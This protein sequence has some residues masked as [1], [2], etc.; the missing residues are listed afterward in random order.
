MGGWSSQLLTAIRQS[1]L[2]IFSPGIFVLI[3]LSPAFSIFFLNGSNTFLWTNTWNTKQLTQFFY[4]ELGLAAASLFIFFAIYR[5]Y[6]S[7]NERNVFHFITWVNR[8]GVFLISLPLLAVLDVKGMEKNSPFLA[9]T[10]VLLASLCLMIAIYHESKRSRFHIT[11]GTER[12]FIAGLSGL[13]PVVLLVIFYGSLL[14]WFSVQNLK[15]F[16]VPSFDLAIYD[17]LLY[18]TAHGRFLAS[19]LVRGGTHLSAHFDPILLLFSIFYFIKPGSQTILTVQ[20]FWV[21]SGMIP[22]FLLARKVHGAKPFIYIFPFVYFLY[23]PLHGAHMCQ[24]HSVALAIPL[25]L[26]ALYAFIAKRNILYWISI[27]LL[28][29]TREDMSLVTVFIGIYVIIESKELKQGIITIG[30]AALY[31][32][33]VKFFIMGDAGL[34]MKASDQA[35]GYGDYFGDLIPGGQGGVTRLLYSCITNFPF[36]VKVVLTDKKILFLL[37]LFLPVLFFP[38]TTKNR[39]VLLTYGMTFSLLG[40]KIPL[41]SI[42]FQYV[43]FSAPFIL[44]LTVYGFSDLRNA[45]WTGNWADNKPPLLSALAAGIVITSLL[46]SWKFGVLLPNAAFKTGYWPSR[47]FEKVQEKEELRYQLVNRISKAIPGEASISATRYIMPLLSA[48]KTINYANRLS[49]DYL[50]LDKPRLSSSEKK[51]LARALERNLYTLVIEALDIAFYKS[52]GIE[53]NVD[54][55]LGPDLKQPLK[56]DRSGTLWHPEARDQGPTVARPGGGT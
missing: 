31:L 13:L 51:R 38:L 3:L 39:L 49:S 20:A 43:T 36:L 9:M 53:D 17:N 6:V 46:V 19:S 27:G 29:F 32:L 10:Y 24:F 48:H 23:P 26:W 25:I 12:Q 5:R 50:V 56:V 8:G 28:L 1:D 4:L 21:G 54:L 41:Y 22:L 18:N 34:L 11:E 35:Y 30:L 16:L 33:S 14:A 40:T 45:N 55:E 47:H 42:Y 44:F 2:T 52:T 37:L 15:H 7:S